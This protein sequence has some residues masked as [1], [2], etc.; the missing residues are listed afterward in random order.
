MESLALTQLHQTGP[1]GISHARAAETGACCDQVGQQ[2]ALVILHSLDKALT[3]YSAIRCW[4][5]FSIN[6]WLLFSPSA[7]L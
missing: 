5:P 2:E 3:Y 1:E 6:K 4:G 7:L